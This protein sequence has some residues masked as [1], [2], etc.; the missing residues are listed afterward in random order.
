MTL[1]R[2]SPEGASS[3]RSEG[4]CPPRAATEEATPLALGFS[5]QRAEQLVRARRVSRAT[6]RLRLTL[7]NFFPD[8]DPSFK[9]P[10]EYRHLALSNTPNG[11]LEWR[12]IKRT[13]LECFSANS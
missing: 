8:R 12:S 4:K 5:R 1:R 13:G 9:L 10:I 7:W 11:K 3:L 2:M 6:I